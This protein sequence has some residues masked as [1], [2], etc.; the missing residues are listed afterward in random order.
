MAW[1]PNL[2]NSLKALQTPTPSLYPSTILNPPMP[3]AGQ[4]GLDLTRLYN[5]SGQELYGPPEPLG[6][7]AWDS[8]AA[9][10]AARN[11]TIEQILSQ[12]WYEGGRPASDEPESLGVMPTSRPLLGLISPFLTPEINQTRPGAL[13]A[14]GEPAPEQFGTRQGDTL[15]EQLR[16]ER[17]AAGNY[18]GENAD[19]LKLAALVPA[20]AVATEG[21]GLLTRQPGARVAGE[22]AMQMGASRAIQEAPGYENLPE[23]AQVAAR[24]APYF[25]PSGLAK[26]TGISPLA[27]ATGLGG[28]VAGHYAGPELGLSPTAGEAVGGL[29][30]SAAPTLIRK[31][32]PLVK[33]AISEG[34][35]TAQE[36]GVL[37]R[38]A[39]EETGAVSVPGGKSL[40]HGM[41][42]PFEGPI[43]IREGTNSTIFG[44]EIV[45]R[46]GV[47][48]T[49]S[50]GAAKDWAGAKGAVAEVRVKPGLKT[51][52]LDK[53]TP[54]LENALL[55]KG[56]SGRFLY[57]AAPNW[58]KLD[59]GAFVDALKAAGYKAARFSE[60]TPEGARSITHMVF[61]P[62]DITRKAPSSVKA[63]PAEL[64]K[65]KT[66]LGTALTT[67]KPQGVPA[68]GELKRPGATNLARI[69]GLAKKPPATTLRL[70]RSNP[71]SVQHGTLTAALD[72]LGALPENPQSFTKGQLAKKLEETLGQAPS[73]KVGASL[74]DQL[75]AS[76]EMARANPAKAKETFAALNRQAA[77][78]I[79]AESAAKGAQYGEAELLTRKAAALTG[80]TPQDLRAR[81]KRLLVDAFKEETGAVSAPNLPENINV[82]E[83]ARALLG[84]ARASKANLDWSAPGRQGLGAGIRHPK[85]WLES[86]VPMIKAWKSE[87][88]M[89][90]VNRELG[91]DIRRLNNIPLH[92]EGKIGDMIHLY[93]VGPD[94][95]GL[96]RVPGFE[97]VGKGY[98][99]GI[100]RK[101]GAKSERAY[102]TFLNYQKVKT[103][104]NLIK[105]NLVKGVSD[106]AAYQRLANIIDHA[107]GYGGAFLK[108]N[109][110]TEIL[111]SQRYTSSRFQFLVDPIV[112]G[113]M[114]GDMVA[115]RAATENL[116]AFAGGVSGLLFLLDQSGIAEVEWNPN[117]TDFGKARVGPQRFDFSAGF[118]PLIR[119]A[120]RIATG[121]AKSA[122]GSNYAVNRT[123]Q[124]IN[125]F[126][127]KLAPVPSEVISRAEWA[128]MSEEDRQKAPDWKKPGNLVSLQTVRQLFMP[129]IIDATLE[130]FQET[131]SPVKA[132]ATAAAELVGIGTGTYGS[133]E[134]A[135]VDMAKKQYGKEYDSLSPMKQA[136]INAQ[137][138]GLGTK[139]DS[140]SRIQPWWSARDAALEIV[141]AEN[142]IVGKFKTY[143]EW[144]SFWYDQ[145]ERE[146]TPEAEWGT[147]LIK[148][149]S[150]VGLDDMIQR[151]RAFSATKDP[152][153]TGALEERKIR[154]PEYVKEALGVTP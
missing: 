106:P 130:A 1:A 114:K 141:G 154:V 72:D 125:F 74:E 90:A 7:P 115:A 139:L 97:T 9:N 151:I 64:E 103:Y 148:V 4:Y 107:T 5:E 27:S 149:N 44:N 10:T 52:D 152:G 67:K 14:P 26:A 71:D 70:F 86:W 146:G 62:A 46:R 17:L 78:E 66:D 32:A 68:P 94:A 98:V 84:S 82:R 142:P 143:D 138:A 128:T 117:S 153:I 55:S 120:S 22:T 34:L 60:D 73:A 30:G 85:E 42:Q 92:G 95:P 25:T 102:A 75:A 24:N 83:E 48:L 93:K 29:V 110:E 119:T 76:I 47:F 12:P 23:W 104:Q 100:L 19:W 50:P 122:T 129:L 20:A 87:E 89:R 3:V 145:F 112:E 54:E 57:S 137:I 49:E 16:Q 135:Q 101:Y 123:S 105:P 80:E 118:L 121:E 58:E 111:F 116:V 59:D 136:E 11:A 69:E 6:P 13:Q 63:T 147:E 35:G 31:G 144:R 124:A 33:G 8:A 96:E 91:E 41:K 45:T 15:L 113:V 40:Y 18:G 61:D 79:A 37:R 77:E 131:G 132:G 81:A 88:G 36:P 28:A 150:A 65:L 39:T 133:G 2:I 99:A 126:R 53:I 56:V 38:L 109:L 21:A 108:G 140:G 43:L 134:A 127:N 51:I